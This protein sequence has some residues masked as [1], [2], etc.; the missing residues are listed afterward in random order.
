MLVTDPSLVGSDISGTAYAL[1]TVLEKQNADLVILG[2]QAADADCY[3][4]AAAVADHLKRPLV[5]QV[6]ELSVEGG[7]IRAKRQTEHG[8]DV[9]EAPLPAV[10]SVSDAINEARLPNIK[11]IMG[12]KKKPTEKLSAADAGLDTSRV[13]DAGAQLV[14]LGHAAAGEGVG[15]P[16]RGPGRRLVEEI[17]AFLAEKGWSRWQVCWCSCST[18]RASSPPTA[19]GCWPRPRRLARRRRSS[20]GSGVDDSW[21]AGLGAHGASKVVVA[22]DAAFAGGLPQPVV[23]AIE[24]L[25]REA[26]GGV[27]FGAGVV[28]ADVAAGLAARLGA[29]IHCETTEVS[30]ADGGV[31]ATRPALGDTVMVESTFTGGPAIVLGR[32]NAF[33]SEGTGGGDA[34]VERV[35]AT[36]QDW[37]T[38]AT[39]AGREEPETGGVDITEA[40]V[41]VAFGRGLGGPENFPL[42]EALAKALGGEVAATR[43]VVDAG[44]VPYSMQVGQTG[45][46]VSPKLYLACGIS[47]AIQHKVGM[48]NSGTIV[49][50][51]K[52]ANAPIF[53]FADLA[54]IGDALTVVPKLAEAIAARKG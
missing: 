2:Q 44:W 26:H 19:W 5:T 7:G 42:V 36:V 40:D 52:D 22:D 45:K 4:M 39:L 21:A 13:G 1:A 6:A 10:I 17:V 34:S 48:A 32:A 50:I 20:A 41:L 37:S 43:A 30:L 8:Y 51:N 12:A 11:A 54:V 49:A 24:P 47:G 35:T 33:A 18:T 15:P 31:V 38:K 16:G 28:S 27:L 53:E 23:D 9:I 29:G 14:S 46:T 3:V 25:A